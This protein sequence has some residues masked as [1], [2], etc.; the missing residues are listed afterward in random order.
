MVYGHLQI[1][2]TLVE[3]VSKPKS[4]YTCG[5]AKRGVSRILKLSR[6][7]LDTVKDFL[8]IKPSHLLILCLDESVGFFL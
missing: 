7:S 1:M 3:K 4:S 8:D 5:W 6:F 2:N